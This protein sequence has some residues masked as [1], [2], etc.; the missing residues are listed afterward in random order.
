MEVIRNFGIVF[1]EFFLHVIQM[2]Q[3]NV[4]MLEMESTT[5]VSAT[6][7]TL[8]STVQLFKTLAKACLAEME[9]NATSNQIQEEWASIACVQLVGLGLSAMMQ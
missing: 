6:I 2:E 7:T 8:E 1:S 5:T 9:P 3:N 4:K